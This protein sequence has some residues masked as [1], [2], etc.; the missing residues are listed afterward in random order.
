VRTEVLARTGVG[1][2]TEVRVVGFPPEEP[3]TS[4]R[5]AES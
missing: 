5:G 1:L 4:T 3:S 2:V